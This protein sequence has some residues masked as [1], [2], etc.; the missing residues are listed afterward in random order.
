MI[1]IALFLFLCVYWVAPFPIQIILLII[2]AF[3]PD[4]IPAID[5]IFMMLAIVNRIKKYVAISYF[6]KTH[7]ILTALLLIVG[8]VGTVFAV[9]GLI[10]L[11]MR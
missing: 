3:V 10:G 5:E 8:I 7:K 1:Y 6:I 4:P 9:Q 11:I 2:D